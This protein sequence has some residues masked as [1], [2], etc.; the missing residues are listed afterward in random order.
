MRAVTLLAAVGAMVTGCSG[1]PEQNEKPDHVPQQVVQA[2]VGGRLQFVVCDRDCPQ[3]TPKILDEAPAV[4]VQK[5]TDP[6]GGA[7]AFPVRD[8]AF[9]TVGGRFDGAV[10]ARAAGQ[11][12]TE[13][14][15]VPAKAKAVDEQ[16]AGFDSQLLRIYFKSG[17]ANLT[18]NAVNALTAS[19]PEFRLVKKIVLVGHM[20]GQGDARANETIKARRIDA[21]KD[22]L[23]QHGVAASAIQVATKLPEAA[24]NAPVGGMTARKNATFE[25]RR[26]DVLLQR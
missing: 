10:Y 23:S 25:M 12:R 16:A 3:H 15:I 22:W 24:K 4:L 1:L 5:T 20:D 7:V 9:G 26:V 13:L 14:T 11:E 8:D 2:W 17:E 18:D 19:E 6:A 21:V